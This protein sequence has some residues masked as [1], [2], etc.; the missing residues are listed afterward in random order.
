M[1][2]LFNIMVN[3][4]V[5]EWHSILQEETKVEGEE[6][7]QIMAT[8]FAIVYMNDA[9]LAARDPAFLQGVVDVLIDTFECVGLETNTAKKTQ[10]VMCMLHFQ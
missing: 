2:K 4:V 10:A 7:D 6:L 5:W 1:K 3:G 9:H 8:L